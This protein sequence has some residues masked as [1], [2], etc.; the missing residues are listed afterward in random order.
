MVDIVEH[1]NQV[2][3]NEE[4]TSLK[5]QQELLVSY[6]YELQ[7]L[8]ARLWGVI[9]KE[10]E[11]GEEMV[12]E[13]AN[14]LIYLAKHDVDELEEFLKKKEVQDFLKDLKDLREDFLYLKKKIKEKDKLKTLVNSYTLKLVNKKSYPHLEEVFLL[15]KQ[16]NQVIEV[17]DKELMQLIVDI[18]H[19]EDVSEDEKIQAFIDGLKRIRETL[20][21][22]LE[23]H[24]LWEKE[25]E[26]YSNTSNIIHAL[27]VRIKN[28]L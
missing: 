13:D 22:H 8:E 24:D 11:N 14:H 3:L 23:H 2:A 27:I 21:G 18:S 6:L 10:L 1:A 7:H 17:Q 28:S 16:L 15:E 25:R 20:S 9:I 4:D 19:L 26:E 5:K 12:L